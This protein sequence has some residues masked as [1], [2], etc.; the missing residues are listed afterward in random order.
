MTQQPELNPS[1]ALERLFAVIREEALANP[2]FARRMLDAA[3][4]KVAFKGADATAA[5]DPVIVASQHDYSGFRSMF[6]TFS[7]AEL[8]KMVTGFGLGTAEDVRQ[9][10]KPKKFAFI[11][12][13]WDGARRKLGHT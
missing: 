9:A 3:G 2:R 1:E 5:V 4:L 13:M 11:D 7:E 6:S 10:A 8:K 12:L